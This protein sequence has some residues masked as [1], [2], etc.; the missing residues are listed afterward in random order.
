MVMVMVMAMNDEN[1]F[2]PTRY[3]LYMKKMML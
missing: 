3:L 2:S 1:D